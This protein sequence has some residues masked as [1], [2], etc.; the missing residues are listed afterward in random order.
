MLSG[1]FRQPRLLLAGLPMSVLLVVMCFSIVR[2]CNLAEAS[3]QEG[4]D[5]SLS[6]EYNNVRV[7]EIP[8]FGGVFNVFEYLCSG[9]IFV[10][11][12]RKKIMP[13][14]SGMQFINFL[15]ALFLPFLPMLRV[16][17][18]MNKKVGG[19]SGKVTTLALSAAYAVLF[20]TS[21]VLF[22]ASI[23]S[24]VG[25]RAFGWTF[26]LIAACILSVLRSK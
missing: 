3:T 26:F 9:G 13:F 6:E 20:Y 1:L 22:F 19:V 4:T 25:L 10:S 24:S 14:P 5:V 8:V 11:A 7:F 23:W 15:E 16:R 21:L 18:L 12:E 17:W 2:M